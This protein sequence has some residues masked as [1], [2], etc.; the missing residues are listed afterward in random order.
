MHKLINSQEKVGKAR[1][2][3]TFH[4]DGNTH[5]DGSPFHDVRV[6]TNKVSRDQFIRTLK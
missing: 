6:F 5:K 4:K 3:V 2:V 1:Y